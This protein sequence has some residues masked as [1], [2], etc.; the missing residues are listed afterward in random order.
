MSWQWDIKQFSDVYWRISLIKMEVSSQALNSNNLTKAD[1]HLQSC[2][3]A[4]TEGHI[5]NQN[6]TKTTILQVFNSIELSF[7]A[8][9]LPYLKVPLHTIIKLTPQAYGCKVEFYKVP[10][11]CV[12]THRSKPLVS[13]TKGFNCCLW[14]KRLAGSPLIHNTV[15]YLH[16]R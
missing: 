3:T 2:L 4:L 1:V 15:Q 13:I 12:D 9:E 11:D 8:V 7:S 5:V 10:I 6:I 16:A 14:W